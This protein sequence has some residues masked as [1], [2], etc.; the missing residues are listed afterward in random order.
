MCIAGLRGYTLAAG[1]KT[2][3]LALLLSPCSAVGE[4]RFHQIEGT[5]AVP[6]NV[7]ESG[8]GDAPAILL[9]HG[10]SQS[11]LSW[12]PQLRDTEL[13][14]RYRLV[15]MDLRGHGGS[16]KPWTR[17]AYAGSAPWATD[18]HA[19]IEALSLKQPVLVGWSFGGYVAMD[20]LREYGAE[21]IAG[22]MLV[23]S[24]GGLLPRPDATAAD[25]EGNLELL[26]AEG[27]RFADVMSATPLS[28]ET[29]DHMVAAFIMMSPHVRAAIRGKRLDN[30]DLLADGRVHLPLQVILGRADPSVPAAAFEERLSNL[31]CAETVV[32]DHVGHSPFAEQPQ[33]FNAEL[34]QFTARASAGCGGMDEHTV[35]P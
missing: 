12:L 30:Q 1:L 33:R 18:V 7:V 3:L 20:Y 24:H 17:E 22:I 2:A 9:L 31:H 21:A 10:F 11:Y 8:P 27:R 14:T 4:L 26:L 35:A 16:G 23:A 6:L 25:P 19:V 34:A 32:F 15:A 28:Q 29:V 5:E 13:T